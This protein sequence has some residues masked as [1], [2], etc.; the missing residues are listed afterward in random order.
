M[1]QIDLFFGSSSWYMWTGVAGNSFAS[2]ATDR[3][4][5]T[6]PPGAG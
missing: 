5:L 1:T 2:P 3:H 4:S 6:L